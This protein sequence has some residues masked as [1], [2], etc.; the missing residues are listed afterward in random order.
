[1]CGKTAIKKAGMSDMIKHCHC[2]GFL[3]AR[4]LHRSLRKGL[5]FFFL[6]VSVWMHELASRPRRK[7][8]LGYEWMHRYEVKGPEAMMI[9]CSE[10]IDV[11][12][13]QMKE[14]LS[15]IHCAITCTVV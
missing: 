14:R 9:R 10:I 8:V 3:R 13:G 12:S 2:W 4:T 1:M 7:T 15:L 5:D 11:L 6:N